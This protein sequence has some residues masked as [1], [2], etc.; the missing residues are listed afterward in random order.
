[1]DFS[2]M[3]DKNATDET[4]WNHI[5]YLR[6]QKLSECD[7]TQRMSNYLKK[8]RMFEIFIVKILEILLIISINQK[9]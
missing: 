5:R 6:N 2:W 8:K 4:K 3:I 1:M 7:W 9:M